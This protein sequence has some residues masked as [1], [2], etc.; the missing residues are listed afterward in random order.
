MSLVFEMWFYVGF[1]SYLGFFFSRIL[2]HERVLEYGY[3]YYF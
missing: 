3:Y 2:R 1:K